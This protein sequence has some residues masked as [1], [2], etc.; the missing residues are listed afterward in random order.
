MHQA[1]FKAIY[2]V[3]GDV[4]P[5][6]LGLGED[7]RSA[8]DD[9]P[10]CTQ[11]ELTVQGVPPSERITDFNIW[12]EMEAGI[13]RMAARWIGMLEMTCLISIRRPAKDND[14]AFQAESFESTTSISG[15]K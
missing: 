13:G 1:P 11:G 4:V 15:R 2:F 3:E 12:G 9:L 6:Q 10:S 7:V 14:L 5:D 8:S